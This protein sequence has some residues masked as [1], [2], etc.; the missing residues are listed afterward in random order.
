MRTR[1]RSPRARRLRAL[2]FG[3]VGLAVGQLVGAAAWAGWLAA[4][5]WGLLAVPVGGLVGAMAGAVLVSN[6]SD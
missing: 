6:F 2:A 3:V 5:E 1:V 4:A